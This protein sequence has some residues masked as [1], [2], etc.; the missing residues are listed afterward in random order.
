VPLL[1]VHDQKDRIT[2][3]DGSSALVQHWPGARLMATEG[4]GHGR[5]L[6]EPA[7]IDA[8]VRFVEAPAGDVA[9]RAA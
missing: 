1:V 4:L 7:V 3:F 2:P 5:I 9:Q 6:S 8:I